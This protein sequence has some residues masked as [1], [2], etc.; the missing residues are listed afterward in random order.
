M[1]QLVSKYIYACWPLGRQSLICYHWPSRLVQPP[2]RPPKPP[3]LLTG[4]I[5]GKDCLI[6][7]KNFCKGSLHSKCKQSKN[8]KEKKTSAHLSSVGWLASTSRRV[9]AP[10]GRSHLGRCWLW[11]RFEKLMFNS[12]INFSSNNDF[13]YASTSIY[14]PAQQAGLCLGPH[15]LF[16]TGRQLYIFC[17]VFAIIILSQTSVEPSPCPQTGPAPPFFGRPRPWGVSQRVSQAI[18]P[19]RGKTKTKE[20]KSSTDHLRSAR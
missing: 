7:K 17:T 18:E 13:S 16:G 19:R 3:W 20:N 9:G 12:D 14:L 2:P 15:S 1:Y 11:S 6:M 5:C 8:V 10:L 4:P